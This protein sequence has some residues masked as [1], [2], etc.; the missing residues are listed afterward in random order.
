[1]AFAEGESC[2]TTTRMTEHMRTVLWLVEHF[3]PIKWHVEEREQGILV[4]LT[5]VPPTPRPTGG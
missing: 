5:G 4:G 1:M 3:V 2:W